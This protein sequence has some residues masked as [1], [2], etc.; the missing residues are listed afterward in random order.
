MDGYRRTE[1]LD[2]NHGSLVT[3]HRAIS[4]TRNDLP[5]VIKEHEF[6]QMELAETQQDITSCINAALSQ[7]KVQHPHTCDILEVQFEAR[8]TDCFIH[9]IL[10]SLDTSV[11]K[12]IKQGKVYTEQ[13]TRAFL[14]QTASALAFAHS[15]VRLTQ[16]IAHRDVKPANVFRTGETFKVGDFDC[17][18]VKKDRSRTQST[19]GDLTYIGPQLRKNY[20]HDTPYNPYKEDVFQLGASLLHL[21]TRT[22][23][24]PVI[25]SE[26]L[27]QAVGREVERLSCSAPLKDLIKRMLA[28]NEEARQRRTCLI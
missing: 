3:L 1:Q 13:E 21:I 15:K 7:A 20:M 4:L 2:F 8:G 27:D 19:A 10:E 22:S 5:V 16:G 6:R 12:D 17:V 18:W 11:G 14:Q 25:S 24:K 9:H 23:P 26:Q 28:Y